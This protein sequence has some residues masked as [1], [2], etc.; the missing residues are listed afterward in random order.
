MMSGKRIDGK[1]FVSH[2]D[3][4]LHSTTEGSDCPHCRIEELQDRI[5]EMRKTIRQQAREI[6]RDAQF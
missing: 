1:V 4:E 3:C 2:D 5:Y 6:Y